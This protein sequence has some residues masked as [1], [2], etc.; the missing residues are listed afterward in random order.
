MG[1]TGAGKS[2]FIDHAT[3]QV[4][5]SAVGHGLQPQTSGIRAVRGLHPVDKGP[6]IFVDTPGF[7]DT[8]ISDIEIMSSIA[9]WFKKEY[10]Q[11]V[12][13]AAIIYLHRISDNRMAG[14]ALKSIR[15]FA[16]T[17]GQ[18]P[19]VVLGTTMWNEVL[20]E[21]AERREAELKNKFW[22]DMLAQGC[23]MQRFGGSY[24]SA[25]KLIGQ[26]PTTC[27]TVPLFSEFAR[28]SAR[29]SKISFWRKFKAFFTCRRAR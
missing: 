22:S 29:Q 12:P 24:D 25:W 20:R 6:V 27:E 15:T 1:P 8:C 17:C 14:S 11:Q 5:S 23:K 19:R 2:T 16:G 3:R 18:A 13:L 28:Q 9:D 21:V 4:G 10:Q 7:D 26:L